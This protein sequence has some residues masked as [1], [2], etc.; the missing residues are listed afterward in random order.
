M[1]ICDSYHDIIK[2]ARRVFPPFLDNVFR[3]FMF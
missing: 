3:N 1:F 2:D